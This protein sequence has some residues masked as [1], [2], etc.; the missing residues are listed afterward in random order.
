M[1][2]KFVRRLVG[3]AVLDGSRIKP[4]T[5]QFILNWAVSLSLSENAEGLNLLRQLY[6][7][8][9]DNTPYREAFRLITNS[10]TGQ[11][12][13]FM[14]LTERFEE[15]GRFQAFLSSYRDKLDRKS[16]RLNSSH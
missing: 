9:M 11:P 13:D 2:A 6:A 7:S 8:Q 16:T 14:R 15:I 12:D 1:A 4:N 5:A 3:N 10:T